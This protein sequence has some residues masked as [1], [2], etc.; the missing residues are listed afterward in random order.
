LSAN[1]ENQLYL[2]DGVK[3]T[4]LIRPHTATASRITSDGSG[5]LSP[6]LE[7]TSTLQPGT[8]LRSSHKPGDRVGA[9]PGSKFTRKSM[10][11]S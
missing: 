7:T 5:G 3:K 4:V 8:A 6:R 2:F 11:E 10:S 1:F 9:R